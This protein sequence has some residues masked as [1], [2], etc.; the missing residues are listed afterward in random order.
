MSL[1]D[2]GCGPGSITL[3]LAEALAPGAVVGVDRDASR[4]EVAEQSAS[5][6]GVANVR[7]Q[8]ADVHELP[9]ADASFDAV[10]A[11]AMLQ[12]VREPLRAL[13]EMYRV[14]KPGGIVGLRDDD[15]DSVVIA[16]QVPGVLR[17]IELLTVVEELNGG[18]PRVGKRY[19][20][21]LWTSGFEE[22]AISASCEYGGDIAATRQRASLA[23]RAA[24]AFV[25]PIAIEQGWSTPEEME[26]LAS[27][28]ASW[29][30]HP[31]AFS[32]VIWCEAV[33]QKA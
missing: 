31:D 1:L 23:V 16:P 24:W 8:T 6:H 14:L 32:A 13:A 30:E 17:L 28:C 22:V 3:G 25:G 19:R 21:L 27:E 11:H 18:D 4:I 10:F 15:R 5:E 33:G 29:G 20:E 2:C 9:F 26:R 7:F 12:H